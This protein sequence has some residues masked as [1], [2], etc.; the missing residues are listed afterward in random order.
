ME[1]VIAYM[2][3][4][5]INNKAYCEY[6]LKESTAGCTFKLCSQNGFDYMVSHFFNTSD[7]KGYGLVAT[8]VALEMSGGQLAIGLIEGDDIICMDLRDG[9]IFLWLIQTGK[10]EQIKVADSFEEFRLKVIVHE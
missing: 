4:R 5:G 3:E 6:L 8:N 10:G 1:H 7:I 2:N 9:S